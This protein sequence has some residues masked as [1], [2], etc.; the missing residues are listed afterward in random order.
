MTVAEGIRKSS[1]KVA[2]KG[3]IIGISS[4]EQ[5]VTGTDSCMF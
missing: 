4:V 3:M 5:V 1:G 2:V